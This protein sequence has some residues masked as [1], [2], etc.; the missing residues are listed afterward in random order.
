MFFKAMKG[1]TDIPDWTTCEA[2]GTYD[3]D[4]KNVD[5][6]NIDQKLKECSPI[7][8]IDKVIDKYFKKF[9]LET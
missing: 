6:I 5:S 3:F 9:F 7:F 2:L 4:C 8:H 1:D